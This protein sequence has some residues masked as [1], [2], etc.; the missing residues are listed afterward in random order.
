MNTPTEIRRKKGRRRLLSLKTA[1]KICAGV[2]LLLFITA[3]SLTVS[4]DRA[5]DRAQV[6]VIAVPREN[7]SA[8]SDVALE[9]ELVNINTAGEEQL[10]SLPGIGPKTA[11]RIL[12]YRREYGGFVS[13]DELMDVSGIGPATYEKLKDKITV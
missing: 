7:S 8:L 1:E 10:E 9:D 3:V 11:G 13:K 5:M 6:S 2:L 12:E 4:R